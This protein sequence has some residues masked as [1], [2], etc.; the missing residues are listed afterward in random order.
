MAAKETHFILELILECGALLSLVE[1]KVE[2]NRET[3]EQ[4][5]LSIDRIKS[6]LVLFPFFG[7]C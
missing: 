7:C 1:Y 4:Q 6:A 3:F 2:R 5:E